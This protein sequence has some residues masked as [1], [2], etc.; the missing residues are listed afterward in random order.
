MRKRNLSLDEVQD[1]ELQLTLAQSALEHYRKAYALELSVSGAEPPEGPDSKSE[2]GAGNG[3]H[4]ESERKKPGL[5]VVTRN[6]ARKKT[7]E[8]LVYSVA[9]SAC[10]KCA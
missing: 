8:G 9:A 1:L 3:E 2:D 5:A 7:R 6:R 4:P 10:R